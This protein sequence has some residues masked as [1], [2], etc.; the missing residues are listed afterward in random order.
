MKRLWI[1]TN[2]DMKQNRPVR[3][4]SLFFLFTLKKKQSYTHKYRLI[5]LLFFCDSDV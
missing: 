3:T 5:A 1:S 2:K 4:T